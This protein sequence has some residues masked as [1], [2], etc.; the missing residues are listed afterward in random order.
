M[1]TTRLNTQGSCAD[2]TRAP[3]QEADSCTPLIWAGGSLGKPRASLCLKSSP[4][5]RQLRQSLLCRML[6]GLHAL[7]CVKCLARGEPWMRVNWHCYCHHRRRRRHH[8]HHHY[9]A[10][11]QTPS[12]C[13]CPS[14][15][16]RSPSKAKAGAQR[17]RKSR[18]LGT[19]GLG[20]R[21]RSKP[22]ELCELRLVS[23]PL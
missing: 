14:I 19:D 7:T 23:K 2:S 4:V 12:F 8:R 10:C 18:D 9:S 13:L 6:W 5:T 17:S 16:Q 20:S 1:V 11:R 21:P 22:S 3:R 15:S